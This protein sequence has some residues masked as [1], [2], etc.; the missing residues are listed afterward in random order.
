MIWNKM[1]KILYSLSMRVFF[2]FL[3][4]IVIC[5]C[6]IGYTYYQNAYRLLE[7]N[8]YSL[9][10]SILQQSRERID[11]KLE[12]AEDMLAGLQYES[13]FRRI[14]LQNYRD[15]YSNY[16][17]DIGEVGNGLHKLRD[18]NVELV[19]S[20]YFYNKNGLELFTV[21]FSPLTGIASGK[22]I[23]RLY[24]DQYIETPRWR[25]VHEDEIFKGTSDRNILTI[26]QMV[27]SQEQNIMYYT[28]LNLKIKPFLEELNRSDF[29]DNSYV[30]I[31]G[32]GKFLYSDNYQEI[33][34]LSDE[35]VE[36]I[37][38]SGYENDWLHVENAHQ[39]KLLLKSVVLC[40]GWRLSAV[41]PE[42]ELKKQINGKLHNTI[43]V[44]GFTVI[45]GIVLSILLSRSVTKPVNE[46]IRKINGVDYGKL[47]VVF[48]VNAGGEVGILAA[49]LNN[50]IERISKLLQDIREKESQR[51]KYE[52]AVI[53]A[54]INPHFLYN[55]L[56]SLR[57][58][59]QDGE[60]ARAYYMVDMLIRF[61]RTGLGKGRMTVTLEEEMEHIRSYLEI[62]TM[63][64]GDKVKY[65]IELPEELKAVRV[66]KL[67]VQPLVE[68]A[69]YHGL[70]EQENPGIIL[71]SANEEE[72]NLVI[73]VFDD[74]KGMSAER[75][76]E[77]RN[78]LDKDFRNYDSSVA[79]GLR[80]VHQRIRLKHGDKYG[81]TI[82]STE[83]IYTQVA[84]ILPIQDE[85]RDCADETVNSR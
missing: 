45:I 67:S 22:D 13:S 3:L 48:D 77:V 11:S 6:S 7:E 35:I 56:G 38:Y 66:I 59:V 73:R 12:A 19:D 8:T 64:Y 50:L 82:Q 62:Q 1:K 54:Q 55:T 28:G 57:N 46:L 60:N 80:N 52:L 32:E 30:V 76:E 2:C 36:K 24:E 42:V 79:Y 81:L 5:I 47:D 53:Q 84:M 15:G 58:L 10:D 51:R 4:L 29:E 85:Q 37:Q 21:N 43:L 70:K 9:L 20:V 39:E 49:C 40:N 44:L 17:Q 34:G 61:Y 68:N 16:Y 26:F 69:L 72:K 27:N 65:Q 83:G 18:N 33:Y 71:I 74:G 31:V 75:L 63:R 23:L 14:I 78:E 25:M 41:I